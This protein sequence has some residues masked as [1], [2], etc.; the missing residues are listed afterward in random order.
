MSGQRA[1]VTG[2]AGFI[3]GHIVERLVRDGASVRVLDD[4]SSGC[5]ANLAAVD[6]DVEI[7]RGDLRD[8]RL[9]ARALEGVEVVFHHAA[10]ASVPR[11]IAEPELTHAIN[12]TATLGLLEAARNAGARRLVLA[13]SSAVYG[14]DETLPK[15]ESL[16]ASPLSPY[17]FQKYACEHYG[18]LYASLYGLET[19]ALRYFNVY[20]P[21][22]DP[23]S[24]YAAVIPL[25][26]SAAIEKRSVNT[27]GDGEQTRD[28]V[29][30]ADVVEANV[31]AATAEGASGSVVNIA[32]GR[33]TSINELIAI[34]GDSVGRQIEVLRE[35]ERVGDVLHSWADVSLARDVL[36]FEASVSLKDGLGQT[37]ESFA[38]DR[39]LS[40]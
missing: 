34:I 22:Q 40:S 30:V 28:F 23:E 1:L 18:R 20:G 35:P 11:S 4:F 3:G 36:G 25:F 29:F 13:A 33:R 19:V 14:D 12:L 27:Y 21:R 6:G 15:V 9:V 24:D 26:V 39:P 10:I 16:T 7:L 5:E 17:A 38:A 31:R 32:S 2:G 8:D 37:V